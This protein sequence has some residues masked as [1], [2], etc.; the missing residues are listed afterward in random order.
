[1]ISFDEMAEIRN[2]SI[3]DNDRIGRIG[4]RNQLIPVISH[5]NNVI[6]GEIKINS[7]HAARIFISRIGCFHPWSKRCVAPST[8]ATQFAVLIWIVLVATV[9]I[10]PG[11]LSFRANLFL[12]FIRDDGCAHL[13]RIQQ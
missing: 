4:W 7:A 2:S 8:P 5:S 10:Q 11:P 6:S 13:K 1:M 9:L 3:F 12:F